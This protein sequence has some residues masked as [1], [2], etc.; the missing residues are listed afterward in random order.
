M[1]YEFPKEC[2]LNPADLKQK[3]A[4]SKGVL[5]EKDVSFVKSLYPDP[6]EVFTPVKNNANLESK[7]AAAPI[8]IVIYF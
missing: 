1:I 4:A 8:S 5:T 6:T 3:G 2:F 7:V